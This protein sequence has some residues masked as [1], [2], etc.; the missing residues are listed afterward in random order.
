MLEEIHAVFQNNAEL[1]AVVGFLAGAL[2]GNYFSIERDR[3]KEFN[4]VVSHIYFRIK[5]QIESRS[6]GI[7]NFDPD[8]IDHHLPW[9]RKSSFRKSV[10]GLRKTQNKA[11][12]YNPA[13][14]RITVNESAHSEM[15]KHAKDVLR[16]IKPR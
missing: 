15:L 2:V 3:R 13:N 6:L 16:H 10:E 14:G 8:V 11:S 5:Q 12:E 1:F 7:E 4:D 9:Y